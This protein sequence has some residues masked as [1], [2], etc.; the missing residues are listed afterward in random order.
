[1]YFSASYNFCFSAVD[2]QAVLK[3]F[4]TQ[5]LYSNRTWAEEWALTLLPAMVYKPEP[6]E[7]T[8][9]LVSAALEP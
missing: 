1:M 3:A 4:G 9:R 5:S 6:K 2:P 8:V 7:A